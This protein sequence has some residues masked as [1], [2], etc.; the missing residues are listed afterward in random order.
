MAV[1]LAE[2][3]VYIDEDDVMHVDDEHV[4]KRGEWLGGCDCPPGA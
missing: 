2:K 1:L 4:G 3:A